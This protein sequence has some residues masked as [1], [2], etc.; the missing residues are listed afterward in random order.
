MGHQFTEGGTTMLG[1]ALRDARY[2]KG[3]PVYQGPGP[4]GWWGL[5]PRMII[6]TRYS[7]FHSLYFLS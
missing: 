3:I 1:R 5:Q 4:D 6:R 7:Y 2:I